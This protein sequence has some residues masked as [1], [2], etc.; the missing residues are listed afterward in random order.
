MKLPSFVSEE[1]AAI[2]AATSASAASAGPI[3]QPVA[4]PVRVDFPDETMEANP[5]GGEGPPDVI[6]ASP[7]PTS[8]MSTFAR[9]RSYGSGSD[10]R[11]LPRAWRA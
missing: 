5:P 3:A 4:D 8:A 7:E 2:I 6:W 11:R 1:A 9:R 10:Q